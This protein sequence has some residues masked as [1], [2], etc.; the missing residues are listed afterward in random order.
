MLSDNSDLQQTIHS[1][2]HLKTTSSHLCF[3]LF[4]N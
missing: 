2:A 1:L 4:F 3:P